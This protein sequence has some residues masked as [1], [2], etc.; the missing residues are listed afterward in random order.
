MISSTQKEIK[1]RVEARING[2]LKAQDKWGFGASQ[3]RN[4]KLTSV[5]LDGVELHGDGDTI[6]KRGAN[7]TVVVA[8]VIDESCCNISG[9]AHGGYLAWLVDVAS[10]LPVLALSGPDS[11]ITS[12][13]STNINM[14]YIAA[15]PVGTKIEVISTV[16]QKGLASSTIEAKVQEVGTKRLIAVGTHVK[17]DTSR[18]AKA[19][20]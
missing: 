5:E 3:A 14:Y 11:W 16:I 7:A 13:V 1:K 19:K 9:N 10:S 4:I 18:K 8:T 15:A 6:A 2:V 12:G 20:L 17:A